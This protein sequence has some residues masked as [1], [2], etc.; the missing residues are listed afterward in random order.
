MGLII[1]GNE[2]V[3]YWLGDL[4]KGCK[5]CFRGSKTVIFITG[6]CSDNCFYCPI[7][8][9]R[10]FKDVLFVNEVEVKNLRNV[11]EEVAGSLSEGVG[12]TG[13]DPL[14]VLDRTTL[15]IK[16]LKECFGRDFHVHLYT[17]GFKLDEKAA[18][19]LDNAGLDELR[20]HITSP[21]SLKALK[22]ALGRAFDVVVENPAMPGQTRSTIELIKDLVKL[23][24]K[25][26]NLN[27]LEVSDL[28]YQSLI[29]RG[30][31]I[32]PDGRSV[33]G[34]K[35]TAIE[36][37][38]LVKELSLDISVHFC[39][40][41]YKDIHQYSRRLSRRALGT[42]RVFETISNGVVKWLEVEGDAANTYVRNLWLMDLVIKSANAYN[43]HYN[44]V[45]KVRTG[46]VIEAL[47]LTPRKIL[48][49]IPI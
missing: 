10:R 32:S 31:E 46:K 35:D 9:N 47:P 5:L 49:E 15:V 43:T 34:S 1:K 37:I 27:E 45:N 40:A 28:N 3:G 11:V 8:I 48:N 29:L 30:F 16:S 18:A 44:L 4:P 14:E 26:V 2:H 42:K 22:I 12:I 20:I 25:Y 21:K 19:S 41:L 6:L 13:G 38:N 17:N 33:I 36:V 24:V 39:P 23:G 7:S